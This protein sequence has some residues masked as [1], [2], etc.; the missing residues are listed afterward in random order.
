MRT[1]SG[2]ALRLWAI[3]C[4]TSAASGAVAQVGPPPPPPAAA[5]AAAPLP[6]GEARRAKL[7][8]DLAGR[9]LK[10]KWSARNV[11]DI[12]DLSNPVVARSGYDLCVYDAAGVL[13]MATGVL[14]GEVCNGRPCWRAR[15][16][17][18]QYRD[19]SAQ[20]FGLTKIALKV[21]A[22]RTDR[23]TVQG[24]GDL[25]PLPAT[26]PVAPLTAQVV[27]S[28]DTAFCWTAS[29]TPN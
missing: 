23:I 9:R 19:A 10:F 28:D 1:V 17:G 26:A 2:A 29:V 8:L 12:R 27:R 4:V 16:W 24:E 21:A 6:C 15:P 22:G 18:Y 25:L 3:V 5:C 11:V 20:S 7:T 13:V 14:P